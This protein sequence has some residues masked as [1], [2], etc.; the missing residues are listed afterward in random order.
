MREETSVRPW[1]ICDILGDSHYTTR[2]PLCGQAADIQPRQQTNEPTDRQTNGHRHN[3][4][5]TAVWA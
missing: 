1:V 3:T 4:K 2:H 5:P